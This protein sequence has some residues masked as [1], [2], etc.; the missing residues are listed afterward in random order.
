MKLYLEKMK[1]PVFTSE[2]I[3]TVYTNEKSGNNYVL[4][5]VSE[6]M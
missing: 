2:D 4:K 5:L 6:G 3:A 1:K